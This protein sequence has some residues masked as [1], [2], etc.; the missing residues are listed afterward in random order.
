MITI[1]V[2]KIVFF[3]AIFI[4]VLGLN[5]GNLNFG[6]T[7]LSFA[8]ETGETGETGETDETKEA[9]ETPAT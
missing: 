4:L 3:L 7:L 2:K 9:Q 5:L 6:F 1:K 8:Q